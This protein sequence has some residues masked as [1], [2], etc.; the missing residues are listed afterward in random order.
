MTLSPPDSF[1]VQNAVDQ[2]NGVMFLDKVTDKNSVGVLEYDLVRSLGDI[3]NL[4]YFQQT[5]K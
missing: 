3:R 5:G 1:M 4:E 2:L